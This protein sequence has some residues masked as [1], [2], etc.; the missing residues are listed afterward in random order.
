MK[1]VEHPTLRLNA[2]QDV[3]KP[4][5]G[6]ECDYGGGA[7]HREGQQFRAVFLRRVE[8]NLD[9]V[10]QFVKA[11]PAFMRRQ[12]LVSLPHVHQHLMNLVI[13]RNPAP[14]IV[15][16]DLISRI[17]EPFLLWVD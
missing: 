3:Q 17:G 8:Q 15:C 4:I 10:E 9:V 5:G 7:K 2:M 6:D 13:P 12:T 1:E 14:Q 11:P 16:D